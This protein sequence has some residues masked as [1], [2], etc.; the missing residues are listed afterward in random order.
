MS[1]D[2]DGKQFPNSQLLGPFYGP[3]FVNFFFFFFSN[4]RY[5][6][7]AFAYPWPI[8]LW[9]A[10]VV[11]LLR[12]KVPFDR[13]VFGRG[14]RLD[15]LITVTALPFIPLWLLVHITRFAEFS[16]DGGKDYQDYIESEP[17]RSGAYGAIAGLKVLEVTFAIILGLCVS[18]MGHTVYKFYSAG[19]GSDENKT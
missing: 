9:I 8:V 13:R 7:L 17:G 15:V 1:C 4:R 14:P 3:N 10:I 11:I 12:M 16:I 6:Y 2:A 5:C 19:R 18:I